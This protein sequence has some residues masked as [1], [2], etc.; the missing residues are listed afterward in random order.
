MAEIVELEQVEKLV[1]QLSPAQQLKLVAIICEHLS[2]IPTIEQMEDN[3]EI[4][5]QKRLQLAEKLLAEVDDIED[6][7]QGESDA[8]EDIRRLR[9]ERAKKICQ[10]D[11]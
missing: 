1:E 2:N 5:Q 11:A 7:S 3:M 8:A 9:E 10:S 4:W 6:D